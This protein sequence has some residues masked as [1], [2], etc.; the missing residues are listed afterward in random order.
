MV[1]LA[2]IWVVTEVTSNDTGDADTGTKQPPE[3]PG[4]ELSHF[5]HRILLQLTEL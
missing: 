5:Q 2:L 3:L 4:S 1:V